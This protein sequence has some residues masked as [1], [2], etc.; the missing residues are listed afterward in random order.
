MGSSY[1]RFYD[2]RLASAVTLSGQLSIRWIENKVNGYMNNLLKTSDD[3]IIAS[4]TDSIYLKLEK[5]VD[6]FYKSD[7]DVNK[8]ISFMDRVCEDK[9]QPFID[10]SYQE[11]AEYVHAYAQKMQMKREALADK[12]IWT[13]KKRYVLNVY[14]NE[15][16]QYKEPHL[17]IMGL[18]VVK[19]STPVVV[20]KK[21][22]ELI[23]II[24]T[25]EES[26]VHAY[27][28][29]FRKFF[30]TLPPE[31]ISFPRGVNNIEQYSDATTVYKKG[32]PI[33]VKGAILYNNTLN[34]LKLEKKY[35]TIKEGEK[36]KFTYLLQPNPIMSPV[37]A[38]PGRLPEEFNLH[39]YID[40]N[41][42][43]VK[44]FLDPVSVIINC[45]GWSPEKRCTL[46]SFFG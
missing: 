4:D 1:F 31:D 35:P 15:G 22:K 29:E 18:E 17:K 39:R 46:E 7:G 34:V 14:N 3:Y 6:T 23:K 16:V 44:T 36:I 24:V 33:Q 26:D 9:I 21:M 32:T 45:V 13:A 25:K 5:L 37:I 10:R 12:G 41:T 27:I 19:S 2:L 28:D 42:Q 11:L 30:K 8:I 38:F 43:F 20:R 40:Y